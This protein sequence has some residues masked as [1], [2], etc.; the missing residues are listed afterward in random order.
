MRLTIVVKGFIGL[1]VLL[2]AAC[3]SDN[4]AD[5]SNPFRPGK[6][7]RELRLEAGKLYKLARQ[8]LDSSDFIGALNRYD[9]IQIKYPYTEYAIQ[10]QLE[11]IYAQYRNFESEEAVT[12]A[13]R[14]LKQHPRHA[15][16]DYVHYLRGLAGFA[17]GDQL[18]GGLPGT[19]PDQHDVGY[20]RKA[21][22][23][24]TQL[25]QKFPKS[26][27]VADARQRMIYLRNRLAGHELAIVRYY[28]KR[29]ALLA[30]AKRAE[31]LLAEYP[32]APQT[33]ETLM[34][35]EQA[36]RG[37]NLSQQADDARRLLDA[38]QTGASVADVTPPP[39]PV[40]EL[41]PPIAEPTTTPPAPPSAPE[42]IKTTPLPSN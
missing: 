26:R 22:D 5:G 20:A 25:I 13:D 33:V 16:A 37:L 3:A 11:S 17:K 6:S 23:D 31:R 42:G 7:E 15:R 18:F 14:F 40:S 10:A 21:F 38:A 2:L 30:A 19:D 29:K 8:S 39:S 36:Y 32:G 28:I 9:Q 41:P 34:L 1:S 24:F 4:V 12:A 27:Y 35:L